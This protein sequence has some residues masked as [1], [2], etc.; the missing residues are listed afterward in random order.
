MV[1][2]HKGYAEDAINQIRKDIVMA[3]AEGKKRNGCSTVLIILAV[4]VLALSAALFTGCDGAKSKAEKEPITNITVGDTAPDFEVTTTDGQTVTMK[5]LLEGKEALAVVL[6]ATWC[7]PCEAEFP[8]MNKVYQK[9]QDKFSMIALDIDA[10]DDEE[11]A[12]KYADSHNLSFPIAYKSRKELG[13]F[14]TNGYPTTVIID[15][16]GKIAFCRAGSIPS[17]DT[18]EKV[19]TTFLGD[20]YEERQLGLYSICAY[21]KNKVVPG[22]EFTVTSESG[23]ETYTTGED[24]TFDIFTDKPEDLKIKVIS[25]PDGYVIDGDGETT[26]GLLSGSVMLPIKKK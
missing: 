18:F 19:V 21:V 13:D 2:S 5:E 7:G 15:R 22:V 26:S 4:I 14:V 11:S 3:R 20:G 17:A 24:G 16:N 1:Y 12:K 10:L 25:V 9:Y 6:F 8:G 23:T